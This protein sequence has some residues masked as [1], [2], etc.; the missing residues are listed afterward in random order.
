[1]PGITTA[2]DRFLAGAR[3]DPRSEPLGKSQAVGVR[4]LEWTELDQVAPE[5]IEVP[6][7]QFPR[8]WGPLTPGNWRAASL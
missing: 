1:M 6:P 2:R 8:V 3:D 4:L 5:T 7:A